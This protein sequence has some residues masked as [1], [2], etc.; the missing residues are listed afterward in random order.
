[1]PEILTYR[2]DK[3]ALVFSPEP[4]TWDKSFKNRKDSKQEWKTYFLS[5]I[6]LCRKLVNAGLKPIVIFPGDFCHKNFTFYAEVLMLKNL[7]Y[8][9]DT[10]TESIIS[11]VG[12]HEISFPTN[13]PFWELADLRTERLRERFSDLSLAFS[14]GIIKVAD[15]VNINDSVGLVL[16]HYGDI[17]PITEEFQDK[18]KIGIFHDHIWDPDF[19]HFF[20]KEPI[21]NKY[22]RYTSISNYNLGNYDICFIG[23]IHS[24]CGS[25]NMNDQTRLIYM[26]TAQRTNVSEVEEVSETKMYFCLANEPEKLS[27]VTYKFPVEVLKDSVVEDNRA[28]YSKQ[29]KRK[30]ISNY[31]KWSQADFRDSSPLNR[32]INDFKEEDTVLSFIQDIRDNTF[33]KFIVEDQEIYEEELKSSFFLK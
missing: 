32:L 10:V 30:I 4:H 2:D 20:A 23:H 27:E 16:N 31:S 9:L 28:A 18:F 11:C 26:G 8:E 12:N 6:D 13:N 7:L 21:G 5:L 14:T 22:I 17:L 19:E 1:M 15:Y 3:I 25:I 33:D 24:I 29:K